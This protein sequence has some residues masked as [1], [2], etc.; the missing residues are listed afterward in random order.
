[1]DI[2]ILPILF[3]II[4][5]IFRFLDKTNMIY[6]KFKISKKEYTWTIPLRQVKLDISTLKDTEAKRLLSR[7]ILFRKL[8]FCFLIIA[9]LSVLVIGY[10]V[11]G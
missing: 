7:S 6:N 2:L 9:F 3:F 4:S 11:N 10:F 8:H 1:M 5:I